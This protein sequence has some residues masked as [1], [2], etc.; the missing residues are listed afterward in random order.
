MTL[1]KA[2]KH[3]K[4]LIPYEQFHI[5]SLHQAGKLIPE[6]YPSYPRA[7]CHSNGT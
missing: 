1:L 4:M 6:Q 3:E 2:L 7:D 5:Q